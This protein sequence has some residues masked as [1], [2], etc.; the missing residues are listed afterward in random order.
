MN[1][2]VNLKIFLFIFIFY[3]TK[4]IHIYAMLMFFAFV[5]EMGHL[6]FGIILGLKPK[7]LEIMPVGLCI[8]FKVDTFDY[9]EKIKHANPLAIKKILIAF[10]GP[11]VNLFLVV[12]TIL[13][14][15]KLEVIYYQE[16]IYS[17]L[18]I[19]IFNLLPIYPLDGGRILNGIIH[20]I[21]GK[22]QA[23]FITNQISNIVM[24]LLTAISSIAI[25]HYKNIA[26]LFIII[27]LWLLTIL[28]NKRYRLNKRVYEIIE[29]NS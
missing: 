10:A 2:K 22:K 13:F 1:I 5:H 16:I 21:K 24:V 8:K 29:K 27:Y 15:N 9:N 17:N 7:S 3:I 20:I 28:E 23:L 26:I 12:I 18:V 19:A 4:Q 11:M 6:F 14:K 25:Y